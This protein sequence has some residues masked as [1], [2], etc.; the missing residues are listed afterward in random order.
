MAGGQINA[1][2]LAEHQEA[3]EGLKDAVGKMGEEDAG[4][5]EALKAWTEVE[6]VKARVKNRDAVG[7]AALGRLS[8]INVLK[9]PPYVSLLQV[10][11]YADEC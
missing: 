8:R 7:K 6:D 4:V 10:Y 9:K 5:K 11:L 3:I 1:A 2:F